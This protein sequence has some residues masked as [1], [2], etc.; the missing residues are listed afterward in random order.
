MHIVMAEVSDGVYR[1]SHGQAI[2][3]CFSP[4][5]LIDEISK[6]YTCSHVQKVK[7]QSSLVSK[8]QLMKFFSP[9]VSY[10]SLSFGKSPQDPHSKDLL[11]LE[12]DAWTLQGR[13]PFKMIQLGSLPLVQSDNGETRAS[14]PQPRVMQLACLLQQCL[15]QLSYHF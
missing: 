15:R 12:E 1:I 6:L 10:Y 3:T 11:L 7:G 14:L 9:W 4:L 2:P 8:L 13:V 5:S